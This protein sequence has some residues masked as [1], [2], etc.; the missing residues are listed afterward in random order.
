[1]TPEKSREAHSLFSRVIELPLSARPAMVQ[2]IG[3]SEL[4]AEV[5][6]LLASYDDMGSFLSQPARLSDSIP[7]AVELPVYQLGTSVGDFVIDRLLGR[8]GFGAVYLARQTS[9]GRSVALK[10]TLDLGEEARTMAQL[11][12]ENV[13][14]VFSQS[15]DERA[16]IRLVCM[17]YV[18]G[19]DLGRLLEAIAKGGEASPNGTQW[20]ETLAR[21]CPPQLVADAAALKDRDSVARLDFFEIVLGLGVKMTEALSAAHDR[22]V[23]HLDVKPSNILMTPHGRP[24]LTDFNVAVHVAANATASDVHGGTWRYMAPEQA[25]AVRGES[26]CVDARADIYALGRVLLEC[27]EKGGEKLD[28]ETQAVLDR[29]VA[30][31]PAVRWPSATALGRALEARLEGRKLSA[32]LPPPG[33]LM[34]WTIHQ[35]L[36]ACSLLTILPQLLGSVFNI[37]Y[38]SIWIV[39]HLTPAQQSCF[40]LVVP[41]YNLVIYPIGA[42][43]FLARLLC[44]RRLLSDRAARLSAT[45][46]TLSRARRSLLH[47]PRFLMGLTTLGWLPGM[48]FFPA[49]LHAVSRDLP[50]AVW[51]HFGASF[52]LSW[53]IAMTYTILYS[54]LAAVRVFYPRLL[55]AEPFRE[56]ARQELQGVGRLTRV[57]LLA[58][59]LIPLLGAA[60]ALAIG[61]EGLNAS[62]YRSFQWLTLGLIGLGMGGLCLASHAAHALG[63]TLVALTGRSARDA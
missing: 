11:E 21:Q 32:A 10:V 24:L 26:D 41:L 63:D 17:Q 34:R 40:R 48:I 46:E 13:V 47:L 27:F 19:T 16:G 36:L 60:A 2:S 20:L 50:T 38:N 1:M 58:S 62:R 31:D 14:R 7:A 25:R 54:Q 8:G 9:L 59:A 45:P 55:G 56:K 15:R 44:W 12:H 52:L 4:R 22:G 35:P 51:L 42:G 39:S 49:V 28:D 53:L 29:A 6:A 43:L 18:A 61:P 37:S 33:P 5:E 57:F 3:D 30:E 23:L